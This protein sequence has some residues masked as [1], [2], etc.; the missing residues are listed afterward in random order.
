MGLTQD[1]DK[2]KNVKT[3][4]AETT[5]SAPASEKY[6]D[7]EKDV[8][9]NVRNAVDETVENI[10]EDLV[11]S[12]YTHARCN[13]DGATIKKVHYKLQ[14]HTLIP[15]WLAALRGDFVYSTFR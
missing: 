10:A 15:R 12:S 2:V 6:G 1:I 3:E 4:E 9:E 7:A 11:N 8:P 14:R 13:A 5:E